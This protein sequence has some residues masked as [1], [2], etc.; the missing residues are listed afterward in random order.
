MKTLLMM[1][2]N[3]SIHLAMIKV[4]KRPLPISKNKNVIGPFKDEFGGKIMKKFVG[5]RAKTWA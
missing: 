4:I 1:L 2:K 3:G 5:I